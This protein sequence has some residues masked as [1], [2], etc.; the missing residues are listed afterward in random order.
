[1]RLLLVLLRPGC[2]GGA[3]EPASGLWVARRTSRYRAAFGP[4][5]SLLGGSGHARS[6]H[7]RGR[8]DPPLPIALAY[9]GSYRLMRILDWVL[10]GARGRSA[11]PVQK[12]SSIARREARRDA[13]SP[14]EAPSAVDHAV[15]PDRLTDPRAR[16]RA[17]RSPWRPGGPRCA[18]PAQ[19]GSRVAPPASTNRARDR[20]SVSGSTNPDSRMLRWGS[21][22][23]EV[24]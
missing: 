17:T 23:R 3:R 1:M 6:R 4:A 12:G 16:A 19:P 7:C 13:W 14:Q 15:L 21:L 8:A 11:R 10:G 18:Q 5:S 20:R 24:T 2:M 9:P 22:G